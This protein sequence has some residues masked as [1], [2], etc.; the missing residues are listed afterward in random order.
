MHGNERFFVIGKD[1]VYESHHCLT[2]GALEG[3]IMECGHDSVSPWGV[4]FPF[5]GL[6]FIEEFIDDGHEFPADTVGQETIVA[7]VSEV[8]IRDM[9]DKA[10]DEFQGRQSY[11]FGG[12]GV[13]VEVLEGD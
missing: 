9:C 5:E 6:G 7:D 11:A 13:M 1:G 10:R 4:N 3:V 2:N 8:A 12:F